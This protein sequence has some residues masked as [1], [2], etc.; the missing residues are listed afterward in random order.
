MYDLLGDIHGHA[1]EL[2]QILREL[3]YAQRNGAYQRSDR[4]GVFLG[5]FIDRGP[6]IRGTL[7]IVRPMVD[8]RHALAVM[9]NHEFNAI[10]YA[11]PDPRKAGAFIRPHS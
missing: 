5:D 1:T 9:G 7:K 3:G 2:E 10:A 6:Q 4:K 11:T 8:G